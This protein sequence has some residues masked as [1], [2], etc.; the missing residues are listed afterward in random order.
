MHGEGGQFGMNRDHRDGVSAPHTE[1]VRQHLE[2]GSREYDCFIF[3]C[4]DDPKLERSLRAKPG[5]EQTPALLPACLASE[6][7]GKICVR[8]ASGTVFAC[9]PLWL[10]FE[11]DATIRS[12][13][14]DTS[15]CLSSGLRQRSWVWTRGSDKGSNNCSLL[16]P[17]ALN[18]PSATH[19]FNKFQLSG[20]LCRLRRRACSSSR[21]GLMGARSASEPK[22]SFPRLSWHGGWPVIVAA[23][24]HRPG[25][26]GELY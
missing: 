6:G 11:A 1:R 18:G 14:A 16:F 26:A 10:L 13:R 2:S 22:A 4:S 23:G 17:I 25:G 19:C 21:Y 24:Q 15:S 12:I 20:S 5:G 8:R 7:A 9:P 3:G